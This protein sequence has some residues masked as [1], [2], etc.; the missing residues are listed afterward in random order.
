M[1]PSPVCAAAGPCGPTNA[2][3]LRGLKNLEGPQEAPL[4]L[5]PGG[6]QGDMHAP[7]PMAKVIE[8]PLGGVPLGAQSLEDLQPQNHKESP[9]EQ[10]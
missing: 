8:G 7:Q 2:P 5:G 1:D 4:G 9:R 3:G 6:T 10:T